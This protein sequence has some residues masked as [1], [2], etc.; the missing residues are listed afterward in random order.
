MS[1]LLR[2][3][4][5]IRKSKSW[6]ASSKNLEAASAHTHQW[7]EDAA[8]TKIVPIMK[9]TKTMKG[10]LFG[11]L[12]WYEHPV[13]TA[14]FEGTDN[15]IKTLRRKAYGFRGREFFKRKICALHAARYALVG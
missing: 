9:F 14:P 8:E 4:R 15:K 6:S 1:T 10:H 12:I 11:L 3:R 7:I 2:S 13:P 5:S